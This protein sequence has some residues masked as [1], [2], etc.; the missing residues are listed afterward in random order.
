MRP[1]LR[2]IALG[3]PALAAMPSDAALPPQYQRA[4]ELKA[5]VADPGVANAFGGAPIERVEY[6]RTDLYRV[7]AGACRLDVA[8][9]DLPTPPDVTGGRRF[10]VKAGRKACGR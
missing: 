5:V 8:I 1:L 3:A 7:S 10:R 9:V 6:V 2:L 4:A